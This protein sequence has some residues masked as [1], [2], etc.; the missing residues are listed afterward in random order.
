VPARALLDGRPLGRVYERDAFQR[1][2]ERAGLRGI[3]SFVPH[4]PANALLLAP[5]A[6]LSPS[7]AK[8]AWTLVLALAYAATLPV[9]CA[10]TGLPASRVALVLLLPSASLAN[11]LAYGQPYPLLLLLLSLS[12]L[13]IARGRTL[14]GGAALAPVLLLKLYA[15]PHAL[16]LLS[17]GRWRAI[18]GMALAVIAL[19]ALSVL[20]LGAELHDVYLREVLPHSLRGEVQDPYSPL[21]GSPSS[22]VHRLFQGEPDLNPQPALEAPSLV[23][24]LARALPAFLLLLALAARPEGDPAAALRRQW[25]A[26]TL[27]GLAASPLTQSYHFVLLA[28]PVALLLGE[29]PARAGAATLLLLFAFATS[30]LPHDS[31]GLAHRWAN[32]PAYPRLLAV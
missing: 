24:P 21:W 2:V 29:R 10:L 9:L 16:F 3:G 19:L 22:L 6:K 17:R 1:E 23:A 32:L 12:L 7:A 25:A 5:F 14:P 11:A 28:L 20:T 26:L 15:A 4:P 31:L 18:A 30:P 13:A 27:A 8:A